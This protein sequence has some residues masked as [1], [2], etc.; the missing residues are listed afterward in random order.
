MPT[1]SAGHLGRQTQTPVRS[2][3]EPSDDGNDDEGGDNRG[4]R[5]GGNPPDP[6]NPLDPPGPPGPP[7][8]PQTP[9]RVLRITP[10]PPPTGAVNTHL[11]VTLPHLRPASPLDN[12]PSQ[13]CQPNRPVTGPKPTGR[14]ICCTHL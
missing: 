7:G 9:Q 4:S 6:P 1:P 3:S 5:G 13:T 14:S 12:C 2:A 8:P 11:S 10:N